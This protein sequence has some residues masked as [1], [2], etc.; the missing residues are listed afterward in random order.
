M[1][2]HWAAADK[3]VLYYKLKKYD[4]N[5]DIDSIR[6]YCSMKSYTN[7]K[8]PSKYQISLKNMYDE[9]FGY[10]SYEIKQTQEGKDAIN[11]RC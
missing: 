3:A 6:W 5:F 1:V 7:F 4:I 2:A 8:H 9:T 10:G 11:S